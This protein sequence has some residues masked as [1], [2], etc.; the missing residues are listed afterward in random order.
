MMERP[1]ARARRRGAKRQSPEGSGVGRVCPSHCGGS[2]AFVKFYVQFCSFRCFLALIVYIVRGEGRK[3]TL[4]PVFLLRRA[5]VP[6]PAINA[7][8]RMI[9]QPV[10]SGY[11]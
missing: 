9:E 7:F 10:Q 11:E 2:G 3:F 5:S 6:S 8:E 4:A 1:K